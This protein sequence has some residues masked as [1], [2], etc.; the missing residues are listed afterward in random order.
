V[1]GVKEKRETNFLVGIF[2]G[3]NFEQRNLIGQALGSPGTKSDIQ[4]YNRLDA[5]LGHVFCAL[6]PVDYPDKIK[7]F[8]QTLT[9][10][11]IH[12]LVIDLNIG[13]NAAIGEV[14][15]G[16][17][18]H[19]QLHESRVLV[20]ITGINSKTEWKLADTTKKIENILS[21]TSLKGSE[22]EKRK[23]RNM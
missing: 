14:L 2:G 20:I 17:D 18:L 21:T 7:P 3:E 12:L 23:L 16:I 9:I 8:L 19:H 15:V 1:S 5:G 13:L 6:T 10:T 4:F 22:I 11:N